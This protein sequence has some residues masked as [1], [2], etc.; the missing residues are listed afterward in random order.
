MKLPI[1]V[2]TCAIGLILLIIAVPFGLVQLDLMAAKRL[3]LVPSVIAAIMGLAFLWAA[4][5]RLRSKRSG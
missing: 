1:A 3:R 4:V 5:G 2:F